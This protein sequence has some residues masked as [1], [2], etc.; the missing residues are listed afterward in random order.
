MII[1]EIIAIGHIQ[2]ILSPLFCSLQMFISKWIVLDEIIFLYLFCPELFLFIKY[3]K[4][5]ETM[6]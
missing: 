2:R 6:S 5:K 3:Y 4:L 1:S